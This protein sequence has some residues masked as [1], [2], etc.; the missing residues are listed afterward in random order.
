[1]YSCLYSTSQSY[2]LNP[3]SCTLH[4]QSYTLNPQSCT[5]HPQAHTVGLELQD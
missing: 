2:T 4:P 3:Q 1:M 5:L